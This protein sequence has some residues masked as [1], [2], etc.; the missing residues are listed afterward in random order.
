MNPNPRKARQTNRP[1]PGLPRWFLIW[2]GILL[3]LI[4]LKASGLQIFIA[5]EYDGEP[6]LAGLTEIETYLIPLGAVGIYLILSWLWDR[7]F[8]P[9]DV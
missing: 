1:R 2:V 3:L 9:R 5:F 8:G 7:Y 6:F 4:I